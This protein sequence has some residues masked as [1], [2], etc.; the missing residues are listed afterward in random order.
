MNLLIRKGREWVGH[1]ADDDNSVCPETSL[2]RR[3]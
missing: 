2:G 3:I 1:T